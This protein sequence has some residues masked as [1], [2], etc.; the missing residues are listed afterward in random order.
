MEEYSKALNVTKYVENRWTSIVNALERFLMLRR[1]IRSAFNASGKQY[2]L[3]DDDVVK[4]LELYNVLRIVKE[5]IVV[6]QGS[7][8]VGQLVKVLTSLHGM[9]SLMQDLIDHWMMMTTIV[10]IQNFKSWIPLNLEA[11]HLQITSMV[12]TER[13][14]GSYMNQHRILLDCS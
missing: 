2:P 9:K 10:N 6:S 14:F 7:R 1:H 13:N 12:Q 3:S 11:E 4:L 8:H 5:V